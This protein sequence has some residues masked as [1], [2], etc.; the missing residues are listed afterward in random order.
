MSVKANWPV[1]KIG[2]ICFFV[3]KGLL[4]TC[5]LTTKTATTTTT[6]TAAQQGT[7]NG[8]SLQTRGCPRTDT[9]ISVLSVDIPTQKKH[10]QRR[11]HGT[12]KLWSWRESQSDGK[13]AAV[14]YVTEQIWGATL[15]FNMSN[16][17]RVC[18]KELSERSN[19]HR[20]ERTVHGQL[21]FQCSVCGQFYP[22]S[23]AL[24]VH[25]RNVHG[26][27]KLFDCR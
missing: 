24:L 13:I 5:G 12:W 9:P 8:A 3:K 1:S 14:S 11:N 18:C 4:S 17:C 16:T 2:M 7:Q 26:E 22:K 20:H 19:L 21:R 27:G 25:K 6:R 10:P 23:D 15:L